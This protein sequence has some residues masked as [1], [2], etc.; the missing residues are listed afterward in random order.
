MDGK[1]ISPFISISFSW[2]A[3]LGEPTA[4]GKWGKSDNTAKEKGDFVLIYFVD[5]PRT[6]DHY[7]PPNG[8]WSDAVLK[9]ISEH[10][11]TWEDFFGKYF[12]QIN[13]SG[14]NIPCLFLQNKLIP[15]RTM[16]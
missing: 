7:F 3:M 4:S 13:I 16:N 6:R 12:V 14:M 15:L 2:N 9:V 5:S 11:S 1:R 10:K 8:P